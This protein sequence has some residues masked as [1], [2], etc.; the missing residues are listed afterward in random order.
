MNRNFSSELPENFRRN[1]VGLHAAKGERWLDN[2]PDLIAE[3]ADK[4]S[5]EMEN[6]FEDLSFHYVAPCTCADG[7][8]AV[9]KLGYAEENSI[10]YSEAKILKFLSG[11][12]AVKL[13]KFDERFCALLL[14]RLLPGENLIELCKQNDEQATATAIGVLKN[15]RQPSL[16]NS[17]FPT[18]QEWIKSLL[19]AHNT[20]FPQTFIRKAQHY[21]SELIAASKQDFLLH[22]DLHHGNILSA[23]RESYLAI[24]PKG[25]VGDIGFEISVFLNNPRSWVLNHPRREKILKTRLEMF[26]QSF[27][28]EP[29]NLRKWAYAEAVLSAWWT[30]EDNGKDYEKWL[31]SAQM[32]D[33]LKF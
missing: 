6:H 11:N 20:L 8:K 14:E 10:L 27:E 12:G 32:W 4:W 16:P 23:Q 19:S 15:F 29:Q 26:S 33:S 7:T 9:L 17:G 13:L 1:S 2:L 22:G 21:F 30:F 3:I 18:L 28:I 5:L 24:D 25:I 31:A